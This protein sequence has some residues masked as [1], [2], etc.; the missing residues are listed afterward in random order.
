MPELDPAATA[1]HQYEDKP[2][3][4]YQKILAVIV[5]AGVLVIVILWHGRFSADFYPPDAARVAPNL[6][7]SLIQWALVL[8]V[9]ALIWPP[10]RRRIHHFA[11][12]KLA[13]VH[14]H[15]AVIRQHHEEAA[16][17]REHIIRQNAHIIEHTKAIPNETHDGIDLTKPPDTR[18]EAP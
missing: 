13:P 8:M 11:D 18:K 10:T 1:P 6:V 2:I 16:K 15:L 9:A 17:Q 14:Q 5:A 7:A 4:R 12:A 3:P